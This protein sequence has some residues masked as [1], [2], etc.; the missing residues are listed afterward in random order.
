MGLEVGARVHARL[1]AGAADYVEA[2]V[3][4]LELLHVVEGFTRVL[5]LDAV[6]PGRLEPGVVAEFPPEDLEGRYAPITPH[7]AGLGTCLAF[8]RACGLAM[9]E[10]VRVFAIGVRDPYTLGERCTEEVAAAI[11]RIVDEVWARVFGPGG[12]WARLASSACD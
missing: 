11:P 7:N 4:G 8:G 10:E 3:G 6:V 1:P 2:S 12:C 5:I 9:P